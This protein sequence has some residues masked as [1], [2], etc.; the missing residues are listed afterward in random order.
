M[1][2]LIRRVVQKERRSRV[3]LN[4]MVFVFILLICCIY[5]LMNRIQFI[6]IE[7]RG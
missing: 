1:V 5:W 2:L 6:I 7:H 3:R 4:L